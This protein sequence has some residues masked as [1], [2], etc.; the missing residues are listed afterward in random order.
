MAD[1][2][3]LNGSQ[4]SEAEFGETEI[5]EKSQQT[6]EA[7]NGLISDSEETRE[8]ED[9]GQT[10]DETQD[11]EIVEDEQNDAEE[12][13]KEEEHTHSY[14]D[15]IVD[16]ELI[17]Q[18]PTLISLRGKSTYDVAKSYDNICRGYT[19]KANDLQR[20]QQELGTKQNTTANSDVPEDIPD[21]V[22]Y[23][24]EFGQWLQNRDKK[25][26][27][28]LRSEMR[29]VPAQDNEAQVT[30]KQA[31]IKETI[32]KQL[33]EGVTPEEAIQD[34]VNDNVNDLYDSFGNPNTELV[35]HYEKN[36]NLFVKAVL[37]VQKVKS[38]STSKR[39]GEKERKSTVADEVR[40][41]IKASRE[42]VKSYETEK[43]NRAK[44]TLNNEEDLLAEINKMNANDY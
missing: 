33:P 43:T 5:D 38:L 9:E 1:D 31:E 32:A 37:S 28:T 15:V 40:K 3:E 27:E 11:D 34:W 39:Q 26:I 19:Q 14:N 30:K 44:P 4:Q 18:F 25:L 20:L 42:T 29:S 36:P 2:E 22:E 16:D 10:D 35:Q 21:P 8:T 7:I 13:S 23:P 17:K 12:S 41:N 6:L 24:K